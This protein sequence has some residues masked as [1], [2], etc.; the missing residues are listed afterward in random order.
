M[1]DPSC[2]NKGRQWLGQGVLCPTG[3]PFLTQ[4]GDSLGMCHGPAI[5]SIVFNGPINPH[6]SSLRPWSFGF[7]KKEET[8][9]VLVLCFG[10][11]TPWFASKGL[12]NG[13]AHTKSTLID[14][15][16]TRMIRDKSLGQTTQNIPKSFQAILSKAL[17]PRRPYPWQPLYR[18]P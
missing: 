1:V 8:Y 12:A 3:R 7:S 9:V 16:R 4:L 13:D 17:R 2:K 18:L 10:Q 6:R 15:Q 5:R 11:N 14:R